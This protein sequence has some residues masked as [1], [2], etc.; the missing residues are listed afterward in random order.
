MHQLD[1]NRES[2]L[3][4]MPLT[5]KGPTHSVRDET[6]RGLSLRQKEH[7]D[8][9][10]QLPK[11]KVDSVPAPAPKSAVKKNACASN[12]RR[13]SKV[14]YD[15]TEATLK[16]ALIKVA[17]EPSISLRSVAET[18]K[19]QTKRLQRAVKQLG[20]QLKMKERSAA[21]NKEA[22]NN[23]TQAKVGNPEFD[24]FLSKEDELAA[25]TLYSKLATIGFGVT[26]D[27]LR[28]YLESL[29]SRGGEVTTK[30]LTDK[31]LNGFRKRS[32]RCR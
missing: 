16:K 32:V 10:D 23:F 5:R 21:E 9:K 12:K 17:A 25:A 2:S 19:V 7:S 1:S 18:F 29:R 24:K 13:P 26:N 8:A 27:R 30:S 15:S 31:Q 4:K 3:K 11:D 22:I 28:S 6:R 20:G 14:I